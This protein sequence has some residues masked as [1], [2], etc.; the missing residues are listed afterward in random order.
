M[1]I[2]YNLPCQEMPEATSQLYKSVR[3]LV[4]VSSLEKR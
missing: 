4:D 1:L 2:V 3:G